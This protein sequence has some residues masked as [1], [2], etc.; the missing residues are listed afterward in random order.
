M[1]FSYICNI[2]TSA[3]DPPVLLSALKNTCT[4]SSQEATLCLSKTAI[5]NL[6]TPASIIRSA[7]WIMAVSISPHVSPSTRCRIWLPTTRVSSNCKDVDVSLDYRYHFFIFSVKREFDQPFSWR[8][9]HSIGLHLT[10]IYIYRAER[11]VVPVSHH[12][13][14]E[15]Q[16]SETLGERCLGDPTGIPETG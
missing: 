14:S 9:V 13:L 4:S 7:H 16:T 3:A 5:L 11:W 6:E 1:L 15:S 2:F 12:S 10:N 8:I